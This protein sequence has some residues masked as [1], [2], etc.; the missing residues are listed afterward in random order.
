MQVLDASSESFHNIIPL[1]VA[2]GIRVHVTVVAT[3]GKKK[4]CY[5]QL[6]H[7]TNTESAISPAVNK[8]MREQSTDE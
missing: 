2:A 6:I 8:T 4:D 1:L 3:E 5:S 7:D